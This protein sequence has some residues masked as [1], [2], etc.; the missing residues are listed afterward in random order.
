MFSIVGRYLEHSRIYSFGVGSEQK[1]YISSADLMTRNQ[2]RRVEIAAP[3]ESP[4]LKQWF[5]HFLDVLLADNVKARQLL[6][7]GS[8]V[9]LP[10]PGEPFDCQERLMAEAIEN[11]PSA[12]IPHRAMSFLSRIFHHGEGRQ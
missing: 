6:P 1:L 12:P 4:E 3:V 7:D 9:N 5:S 2:V 10:R 8:Y 11:A